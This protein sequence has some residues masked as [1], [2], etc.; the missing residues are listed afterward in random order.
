MLPVVQ[1]N[2]KIYFIKNHTAILL[3]MLL[4]PDV[5]SLREF[6]ASPLGLCVRRDLGAAIAR[7][8]PEAELANTSIAGIGFALPYL[9]QFIPI[10]AQVVSVM[11]PHLGAMYW[12]VDISNHTILGNEAELPFQDNSIGRILVCH[13][14][15]H[16][17]HLATLMNELARVLVPGGRILLIVPNRRGLWS[18]RTNNPFGFGHP[19]H[20]AQARHRLELAGLTPTGVSSAL[21]YSPSDTRI[22]LRL[23]A[24]IERMGRLC[25]PQLGGVLLVEAEKQ[26]YASIPEPSRRMILP[27]LLYPAGKTA[28]SREG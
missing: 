7:H 15:E 12:P 26:L 10:A 1:M 6:Y 20:T 11:F 23:S 27:N 2:E 18:T 24:V 9:R 19:F 13:C 14:I 17:P 22:V 3:H 4:N 25:L 8:W 16:S 21:F 28:V 5:V